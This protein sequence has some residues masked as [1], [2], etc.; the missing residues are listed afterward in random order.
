MTPQEEFIEQ[1]TKFLKEHIR[2]LSV[3]D[4]AAPVHFIR[5]LDLDIHLEAYY[6]NR[7]IY[8]SKVDR[9]DRHEQCMKD[10]T[11][12]VDINDINRL[13]S[14]SPLDKIVL[15]IFQEVFDITGIPAI[16]LERMSRKALLANASKELV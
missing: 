5:D 4:V 3:Q 13:L 6:P 16:A 9:S 8:S 2:V 10:R 12:G 11:W 7:L 15:S 1:Q 14:R